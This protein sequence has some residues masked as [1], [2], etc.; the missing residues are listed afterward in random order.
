MA[1]SSFI[2]TTKNKIVKEFIKDKEIEAAIGCDK[3]ETGE[4]L[5]NTHIFTQSVI[6]ATYHTSPLRR[7]RA[8]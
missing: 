5:V 8:A 6:A 7:A 2:G 1:N 3:D 4:K